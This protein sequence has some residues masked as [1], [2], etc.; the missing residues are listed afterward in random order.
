MR[1]IPIKALI[2][3]SLISV[4]AFGL[5]VRAPTPARA[6]IGLGGILG[7]VTAP[8]R[9]F[10]HGIAGRP[11]A[12]HH[13]RPEARSSHAPVASAAPAVLQ[14][15]NAVDQ[16]TTTEARVEP[17][18]GTE[19]LQHLPPRSMRSPPLWPATSPSVYEDLVGYVFWP[20]DYADRLWS[21]GYG[22][23]MN[24]MFAPM[25]ESASVP[26]Q[27][28]SLIAN[29]MCSDQARELADRPIA[30]LDASLGLTPTQRAAL[31]AL[32][33]ALGEAIDRGRIAICQAAPASPADRLRP[34]VKG[35]WIMWDAAL[36]LR[37]PLEKFYD[38]L[39]DAQKAKLAGASTDQG[40]ARS[41]A[42]QGSADWP[43]DRI[44]RMIGAS[45]D[46][47]IDP[48]S[49]R[50]QLS[51][52]AK[53][54]ATSC[55]RGSEPTPMSRLEAVSGRMKSLRYVVMNIDP[56]FNA[57]HGSPGDKKPTDSE[58]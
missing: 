9:M 41:C 1:L 21:H 20:S 34:M 8:L 16:P 35:L 26:D 37:A 12:Y 2:N 52:M 50:Q 44:A 13:H 33:A 54:L 55:P 38:K 17:S 56:P 23:I 32:R 18:P 42:D 47:T 4:L 3:A 19:A 22:D 6:G 53:F 24:A 57:L 51:E 7:L 43:A 29:G 45:R 48:Q 14:N 46:K 31:D 25:A 49:L 30:R 40:V 28:A 36:L 10:G 5:V 11:R 15:R 39:D 58:H 27:A